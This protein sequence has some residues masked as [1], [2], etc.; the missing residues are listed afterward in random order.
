MRTKIHLISYSKAVFD[1]WVTHSTISTDTLAVDSSRLN[2]NVN[3]KW[4]ICRKNS[5][6]NHL[7]RFPEHS[8]SV[9][10]TLLTEQGDKSTEFL[11]PMAK[12]TTE[13]Q[14]NSKKTT[15]PWLPSFTKFGGWWA[16]SSHAPPHY[17][18]SPRQVN[19]S[20]EEWLSKQLPLLLEK[21]GG[22]PM[23]WIRNSYWFWMASSFFDP[24]NISRNHSSSSS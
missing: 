22:P 18:T 15:N 24:A 9:S 2:I 13:I 21:S 11:Y 10:E 17:F 16:Q 4:V 19:R 12:L 1:H 3:G 6:S 23:R 5:I 20:D 7:I 8:N 14:Q